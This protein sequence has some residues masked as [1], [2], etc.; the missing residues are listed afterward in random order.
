MNKY[1]Q[2]PV[3][4]DIN[5]L[6]SALASV[7]NLTL[8]EQKIRIYDIAAGYCYFIRKNHLLWMAI[9]EPLFSV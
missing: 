7:K 2:E 4:R 1:D 9:N 3:L 5:L 6:E 8:F